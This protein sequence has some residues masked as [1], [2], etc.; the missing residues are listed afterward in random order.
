MMAADT[1]SRP[2]RFVVA[3]L[4]PLLLGGH[5]APA[6]GIAGETLASETLQHDTQLE[7]FT[8]Q[9]RLRDFGCANRKV[10]KTEV[11]NRPAATASSNGD[12]PGAWSERW[13]IDRCGEIV[14]WDI[15]FTPA[16]GRGIGRQF[17]F[18]KDFHDPAK[19]P[20]TLDGK[21]Y[22]AAES[23]D[24]DRVRELIAQ[25]AKVDS[26]SDKGVPA[27][28]AAASEGHAA[29]VRA[30]LE[31]GADV[32]LA[33]RYGATALHIA[34]GQGRDEVIKV[35]L[36][37]G[38]DVNVGTPGPEVPPAVAGETPLF[39]A[40]ARHP[41]TAR[42]LIERGAD[43]NPRNGRG[44]PLMQAALNGASESV[45]ILLENG[46][47]ATILNDE[48]QMALQEVG[49]HCLSPEAAL[50]LAKQSKAGPGILNDALLAAANG[51]HERSCL[52]F[53]GAL[54]DSG[55]DVNARAGSGDT[56]LILAA[57]WDER[58]MVEFLLSRGAD[59]T[60]KNHN[61]HTARRAATSTEIGALLKAAE[62]KPKR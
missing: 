9:D 40:V 26:V 38:A 44:T 25:G 50:A 17:T 8:V 46:A 35:L 16:P 19:A 33:N 30:L 57:A 15:R 10:V 59:P 45:V 56:P 37:H 43:V 18:V 24:A 13:Y 11:K 42:L 2:G 27:L 55:A 41:G 5:V 51:P 4:I 23:G 48:G 32:T 62:K 20:V 36:D 52:A 21:L 7:L 54:L 14:A 47:D 39:D 34:A 31:S 1:F 58:E 6:A 12:A 53:A 28:A 49:E 29:A 3:V 60:L 22:A 61:G